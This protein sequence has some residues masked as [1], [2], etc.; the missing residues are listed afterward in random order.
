MCKLKVDVIR[1]VELLYPPKN[2]DYSM[3]PTTISKPSFYRE[4]LSSSDTLR[5]DFKTVF[6]KQY[7]VVSLSYFSRRFTSRTFIPFT[8]YLKPVTTSVISIKNF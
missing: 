4:L 8:T 3:A 7:V 2:F 5:C 1:Y 6:E